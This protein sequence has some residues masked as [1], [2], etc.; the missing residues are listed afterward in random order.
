[1]VFVLAL[2]GVSS[3]RQFA[4]P[5]IVGI[6]SGCYSSVCVASPLWYLL[7]GKGEKEKKAGTYSK[8]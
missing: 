1:M 4:I 5:L 7:M 3:V 8:K 6:I 2:L